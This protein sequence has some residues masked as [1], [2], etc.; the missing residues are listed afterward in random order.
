MGLELKPSKT[1][2]THTLRAYLGAVGFD[3]LGFT[4]RQFPVGRT[5]SGK[6]GR[7]G[8][9][10]GF[11]T[12]IKPSK[13]A[14]KRH[15]AA[16]K[17]VIGCYQTA[18]QEVLVHYLNPVM[19]GWSNYYRSSVAKATFRRLDHMVYEKLRAWA[20]RRH[21]QTSRRWV[22]NKYWRLSDGLGWTFAAR[23]GVRLHT[24]AGTPILRHTKVAG[25]RSPFD[26]DWPYWAARLGRHPDLPPP[27]LTA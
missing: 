20:Q 9:L 6:H 22:A 17:D 2:L 10:L 19:R 1:R 15:L 3:F 5:H 18:P 14:I 24:Y 7:S 21:Q 16:V 13:E 12:I 27:G 4:V 8:R 26:G 23:G 11:K 25:V